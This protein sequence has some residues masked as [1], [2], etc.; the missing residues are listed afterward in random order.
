MLDYRPLYIAPRWLYGNLFFELLR[1]RVPTAR[2]RYE[3]LVRA[4]QE[5][6]EAALRGSG[7]PA[8]K[9]ALQALGSGR[10]TLGTLHTIGGN[11]MRFTA[12]ETP[13]RADEAWRREMAP[14]SRRSVTAV[15]WPLLLLYGYS[16]R[17][18]PE[19]SP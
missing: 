11:P 18:G 13:V 15:T 8:D 2:L 17:S 7:A 1:T 9:A 6:I 14:A 10:V 16:L 19:G 5:Y 4:P 12:G 3:D